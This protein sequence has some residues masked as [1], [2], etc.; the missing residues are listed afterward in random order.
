MT[1]RVKQDSGL[2]L[3]VAQDGNDSWSGRKG[4]PNAGLTDGPL[5]TL[6]RAR[7]LVREYKAGQAAKC[8]I[9]V[10]VRRGKF[11][12]DDTLILDAE[13][14]GARGF[15]I[16]YQ[17]HHAEKVILSGGRRI[18]GWKPYK[19]EI[20]RA[21]IGGGKGG[22]WKFRQLFLNG[23]RQIRSRYPKFDAEN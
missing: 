20:V 22:V 2:T 13:D 18:T 6:K 15:P 10:A 1:V 5:A 3:Y 11:Y 8:L 4:E 21:E 17:A 19:G 9:T 7:D 23:E 16:R 14:S 12:L